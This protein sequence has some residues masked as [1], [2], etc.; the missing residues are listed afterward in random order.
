MEQK[1]RGRFHGF[2]EPLFLALVS[3]A[4]ALLARLG[5]DSRGSTRRSGGVD[6]DR[7]ASAAEKIPDVVVAPAAGGSL[8]DS[9]FSSGE[10]EETAYGALEK[11]MVKFIDK[12]LKGDKA[13]EKEEAPLTEEDQLYV[14]PEDMKVKARPESL[15]NNGAETWLTGIVEVEL[16][17]DA[18]L[19]NIE[20]TAQ[21][22]APSPPRRPRGL[23]EWVPDPCCCSHR[24]S[25]FACVGF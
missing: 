15:E 13:D 20:E 21:V 11:E 3:R 17:T 18:K 5:P 22:G 1:L 2:Q 10:V 16:P 24:V 23:R 9:Q 12:R 6:A 7:L 4:A 8:L 14:V 19:R 25:C